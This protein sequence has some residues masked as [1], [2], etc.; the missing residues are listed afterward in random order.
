VVENQERERC[1]TSVTLHIPSTKMPKTMLE[2]TILRVRSRL[3]NLGEL[4]SKEYKFSLNNSL[5]IAHFQILS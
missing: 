1:F 4:I 2:E 5:N 3:I